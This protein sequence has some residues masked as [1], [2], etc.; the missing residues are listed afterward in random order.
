MGHSESDINKLC[1]AAKIAKGL[2]IQGSNVQG[3]EHA[4][5]DWLQETGALG[6]VKK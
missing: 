2:A 3:A 6:G 1:P 4:I 5:S